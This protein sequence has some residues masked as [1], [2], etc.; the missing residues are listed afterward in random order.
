LSCGLNH[1]LKAR[2]SLATIVLQRRNV[3]WLELYNAAQE[4][5]FVFTDG[6]AAQ[7]LLMILLHSVLCRRPERV[8][9][10]TTIYL[11]IRRATIVLQRRS[12]LRLNSRKAAQ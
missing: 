7:L 8:A 5:A 1:H 10:L 11:H 9:G 6:G 3:L 2:T 4:L 12:V